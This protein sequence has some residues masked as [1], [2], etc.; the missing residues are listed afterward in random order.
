VDGCLRGTTSRGAAQAAIDAIAGEPWFDLLYLP[1]LLPVAMTWTDVDFD[2]APVMSRVR[3]PILLLYGDDEA[4]PAEESIAA[5]REVV[6]TSGAPLEVVRLPRSSHLPTIDGRA[7]IDAVDPAYEAAVTG[8]LEG[9]LA[10][11]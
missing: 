5:W 9:V 6:S 10:G 11:T 3:C 4:V 8:W 2:P 7:T 1:R